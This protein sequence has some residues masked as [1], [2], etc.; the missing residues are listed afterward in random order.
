MRGRRRKKVFEAEQNDGAIMR[1]GFSEH[2]S[3]PCVTNVSRLAISA[4][5][6]WLATTDD[7]ARTYI[8]NL[9]SV[10]YHCVLPSFRQPVQSLTFKSSS[11]NILII[12]FPSNT[13]QIF[14]V[15]SC[16]FPE[17]SKKLISSLPKR[18]T[19]VHDPILGV[20]FD[21]AAT[22]T[23]PKS[24]RAVF[25]GSTW[26]CRVTMD[27][28]TV[29]NTSK[30]RMRESNLVPNGDESAQIVDVS[31]E[32]RHWNNFKMVTHYRPILYVDF[33]GPGELVVVERPLVD[34]LTTLPP[35]YFKPKYGAS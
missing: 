22:V 4:D 3:S 6:Q 24:Q 32:E 35:A 15:E 28:Q 31:V 30:K 29:R 25:W 1:D 18:F 7:L 33:L 9:D 17:W 14:D 23:D 11:P 13:F 26:L 21:P 19:H 27:E 16:I 34:V 8:F 10:Q 20:T 2:D 12:S 5:G